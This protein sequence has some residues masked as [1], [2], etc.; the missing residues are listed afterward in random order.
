MVSIA[1]SKVCMNE[2][3]FV[4][5]GMKVNAQYCRDVLLPMGVATIERGERA[6]PPSAA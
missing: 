1:V 2:L 3:I 4:D 6:H 5:P